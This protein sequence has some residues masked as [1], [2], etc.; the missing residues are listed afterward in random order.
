MIRIGKNSIYYH[1]FSGKKSRFVEEDEL[2]DFLSDEVRLDKTVTF[3]RIFKLMLMHS[4]VIDTVF[5]VGCLYGYSLNQY[6]EEFMKFEEEET[7]MDYLEVYW[8]SEY[9]D[10]KDG[11]KK[12]L[13]CYPSFHGQS[14]TGFPNIGLTGIHLNNLR[15]YKVRLNTLIQYHDREKYKDE[16]GETRFNYPLL[17]EGHRDFRLFDMIQGILHE[18]SFHGTPEQRDEFMKELE[19]QAD[20]IDRGEEKL[21]E[22]RFEDDKVKLYNEDGTFHDYLFDE[23]REDDDSYECGCKGLC[24]CDD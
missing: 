18:I 8:G 12:E 4:A 13:V 9:W 10:F 2:M 15:K 3:E 17:I 24:D 7:S 1:H 6:V 5:N 21:Y 14:K 22:M 23:D 16:E 11:G 20:R 19:E